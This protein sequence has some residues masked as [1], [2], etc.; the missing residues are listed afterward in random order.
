MNDELLEPKS[1][2]HEISQHDEIGADRPRLKQDQTQ[3]P[4]VEP[5]G[6]A[7]R[8]TTQQ[9]PDTIQRFQMI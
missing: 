5:C 1:N 4:K 2:T 3:S 6:S 9:P 7:I 8:G